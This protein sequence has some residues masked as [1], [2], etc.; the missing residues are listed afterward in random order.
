MSDDSGWDSWILERMSPGAVTFAWDDREVRTVYAP[1]GTLA[2]MKSAWQ[3]IEARLKE[4][5]EQ[6]GRPRTVCF[7]LDSGEFR[8]LRF[9]DWNPGAL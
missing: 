7:C 9:P 3:W 5:E 4:L 1:A 8:G 2:H 6:R